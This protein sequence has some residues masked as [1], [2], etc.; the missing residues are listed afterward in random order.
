MKMENTARSSLAYCNGFEFY[1]IYVQNSLR[2]SPK[3]ILV[4][5]EKNK[6]KQ[7]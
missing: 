6:F 7:L 2:D 3:S 5:R 1:V 4:E